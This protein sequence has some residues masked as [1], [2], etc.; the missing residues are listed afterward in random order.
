MFSDEE[1]VL[2]QRTHS[3]SLFNCPVCSLGFVSWQHAGRHVRSHPGNRN[4]VLPADPQRLL[5]ATCKFRRCR[6]VFVGLGM[7]DMEDHLFSLHWKSRK[8][9][10][11]AVDWS[12]RM[13]NNGKRIFRG[14]AA[15][16]RHAELHKAGLIATARADDV[17]TDTSDGGFSSG[18]DCL[19]EEE[20][21]SDLS[22][23]SER[24]T[25]HGSDNTEAD[26]DGNEN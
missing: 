1:Y 13:C 6:K 16:L 19:S 3:D 23:V 10:G 14:H 5:T 12:C 17:E 7:S 18:S 20:D 4:V 25:E 24:E 8:K 2:H 11:E 21:E 15:A 22:S 9:G 26:D